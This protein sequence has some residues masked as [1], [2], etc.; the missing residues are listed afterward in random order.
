[1]RKRL[2]VLVWV[3]FLAFLLGG[4]DPL[5]VHKVTSTIFDGVPSLPPPEQYCEAYHEKKAQDD[6]DKASGV[7]KAAEEAD[8]GS[9]HPPYKEKRCDNCHDKTKESGLIKPKDELCFV[10]HPK[11]LQGF[12]AHGPAAVGSCLECHEPHSSANKS[13]LKVDKGKL[14]AVCH[15]ESRLAAS[16]HDK[17][18]A[19]GLF[20]TDCHNPHAG[21]AKYFLR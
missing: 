1:M 10:C 11:I 15:K 9:S 2:G 21:N 17:V 18:T 12:Y 20:C 13:L 8:K 7:L 3:A 16:M 5:T 6:K 14:C 19:S 4:C